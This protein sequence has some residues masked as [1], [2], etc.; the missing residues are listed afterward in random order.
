MIIAI[1]HAQILAKFL[2]TSWMPIADI[3]LQNSMI[4]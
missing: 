3:N 1:T 2:E 4:L